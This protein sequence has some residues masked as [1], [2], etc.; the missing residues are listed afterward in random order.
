[1]TRRKIKDKK[2]KVPCRSL[3]E[4]LPRD[5]FSD[6]AYVWWHD[7]EL[8]KWYITSRLLLERGWGWKPLECVPAPTVDEL[9]EKL[10][11]IGTGELRIIPIYTRFASHWELEALCPS[12]NSTIHVKGKTFADAVCKLY[13]AL[14]DVGRSKKCIK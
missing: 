9:L 4:K 1:M 8:H 2:D 11:A 12:W 14:K 3:C 7:T 5:L 6:T 13:L 10:P